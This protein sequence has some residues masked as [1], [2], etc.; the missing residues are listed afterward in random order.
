MVLLSNAL[1]KA[2]RPQPGSSLICMTTLAV[3]LMLA[4][5][6]PRSL[7]AAP[8]K[9]KPSILPGKWGRDVNPFIGTG[10]V[11][12]LCGNNFPGATVPFGMVRLSPDTVSILGQRATNSSGYYYSDSKLLGFSHTRLA[13]TGA[14]D[15][16]NYLVI[17][18]TAETAK[19]L[20]R[21]MN[22]AYSHDYEVAFPGYYGVVLPQLGLT[23]EL[24][25][26]PRVGF[27]RYTFSEGQTP[28]IL[29]HVSSV[30]GKGTSQLGEVRIRPET[31]EVEGSVKTFGTFSKRYGGLKSYFVARFNR[32]IETFATWNGEVETAGQAVAS[33]DDVGAHL[34]FSR[35]ESSKTVELKLALSYVSLENARANLEQEAGPSSFDQTLSKAVA[36]WDEKLG[37]IQVTGGSD[38]QQSIFRSA[39]YHSFQMPSV[40]SDANGEYLGF[41]KGIHQADTFHY[42]TDMS[43]WDT[44]RTVHPLF[45]LV[46]R[47]EQKEMVQS[48]LKMAEQG[49]YLPRW[50]SGGGYTNSMFGTPADIVIAESYLKGIRGFDIEAAYDFMRKTALAPVPAG[51]PFSGRSGVEHYLNH[52][53]CPADLMKKSVASTIEYCYADHAI[54]GLAEALGRRDDAI[55]FGKHA[56]FYQN[57]FNP[58]TQFFHPRDSHGKFAEA[59]EPEMLTYL[60][61]TGKFTH[62][63]VEGSAWQWRWGVPSDADHLVPLFK[64]REYFIEQL[65]QFFARSPSAVGA[66]PNAYYWHGN[67][68]D[69][70][71]VY[72]FNHAGRPDLTQKWVRWILETKYGDRE[73]GLDGNDDGGTLSAWYVL[74]SL[75]LFPT[76][77]TDRYEIGSPIWDR[78]EIMIQDKRLTIVAENNAPKSPFVQTVWLNDVLLDRTWIRHH[79]I[80]GGGTL[81]FEMGEAPA[82]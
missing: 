18:C 61:F 60:D 30:L 15:G 72:L 57:L 48:L 58:E 62:A 32:P 67:Q 24:T 21:G 36:L 3:M 77:G 69:L 56:R 76:A 43:L 20:R 66:N 5:D 78:A 49:G 19:S 40:F 35:D 8:P 50:P 52:D 34:G 80:A 64:S 9:P 33:G 29:I 74:S 16:G 37:R 73:N 7:H 70:Y 54:A 14:T 59:F 45:N 4:I 79:E 31:N 39:L 38:R 23:A 47:D 17:P 13:G 1:V 10:G 25:A 42:Y 75:G 71:A 81:K 28:H 26:T 22:A 53:Y 41:D 27:H 12:Y 68:P 63:Y 51:S 44:F 82:K 2:R 46:A 55:L 65:E 6:R 11:S